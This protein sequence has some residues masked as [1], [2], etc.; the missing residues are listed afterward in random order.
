VTNHKSYKCHSFDLQT[1]I[2]ILILWAA[3]TNTN[4][5]PSAY[6]STLAATAAKTATCTNYVLTANTWI[7]VLITTANTSKIALTLNINGTA[8]G[9]DYSIRFFS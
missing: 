9:T 4:T 3:P 6:C 1:V 5:V 7:H 8:G 2:F